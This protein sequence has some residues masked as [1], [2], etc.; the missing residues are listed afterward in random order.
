MVTQMFNPP[1]EVQLETRQAKHLHVCHRQTAEQLHSEQ[2]SV[3]LLSD[4]AVLLKSAYLSH[5]YI[6]AQ[7]R[8]NTDVNRVGLVVWSKT[9]QA[10]R[11]H[12]EGQFEGC[13]SVTLDLS[14][15]D[16]SWHCLCPVFFFTNG[17]NVWPRLVFIRAVAGSILHG[18]A[19]GFMGM[20]N[21]LDLCVPVK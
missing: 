15:D 5:N 14:F 18:L 6:M 10:P 11:K 7:A 8:E 4:W 20:W 3:L 13:V 17:L 9:R 21:Q 19:F 12:R 1:D 2:K 16:V